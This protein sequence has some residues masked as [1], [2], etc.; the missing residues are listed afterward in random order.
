MCILGF[1]SPTEGAS[2]IWHRGML[3]Y[4]EMNSVFI[5]MSIKR[6]TSFPLIRS[7][8]ILDNCTVAVM[9][10]CETHVISFAFLIQL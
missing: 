8:S 9:Y 5:G 1:G 3:R 7:R 4:I 2:L 10:L 6:G